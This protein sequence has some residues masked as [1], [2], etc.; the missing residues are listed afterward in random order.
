[1]YIS[2]LRFEITDTSEENLKLVLSES[3]RLSRSLKTLQ[4]SQENT[5]AGIFF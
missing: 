1:M 2:Y 3:H 5:C 4:N